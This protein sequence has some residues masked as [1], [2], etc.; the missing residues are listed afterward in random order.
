MRTSTL[1]LGA[2]LVAFTG[3][4]AFAQWDPHVDFSQQTFDAMNNATWTRIAQQDAARRGQNSPGSSSAK[5]KT[6]PP[7]SRPVS[8]VTTGKAGV[9]HHLA[10]SYP[11]AEQAKAERALG[12]LLDEYAKLEVGLGV[13]KGDVAGAM[14]L[15]AIG[16]Y[17]TYRDTVV[18]RA[19][20]KPVI[21]QLRRSL[22]TSAA[23]AAATTADRRA[24]YEELVILGM[25]VTASHI[26]LTGHADRDLAERVRT[27]AKSYLTTFG[28]DPDTMSIGASGI[29]TR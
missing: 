5:A 10:A 11:T 20:Y 6:T 29:A 19:S 17:E 12:S 16:S 27:A 7:A 26:R 4:S 24:M 9:A 15:L 28:F 23:F 22:A 14:A 13:P 2:L 1:V 21:D 3:H 8:T 18:D 25:M